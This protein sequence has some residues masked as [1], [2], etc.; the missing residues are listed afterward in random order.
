MNRRRFLR[1]SY[2]ISGV[3]LLAGTLRAERL[4]SSEPEPVEKY[5]RFIGAKKMVVGPEEDLL[6]SLAENRAQSLLKV[7][8]VQNGF[9]YI[10]EGQPNNVIFRYELLSAASECLDTCLLFF[11]RDAAS[12][13]VYRST[14][15]GFHL[16]A[17]ASMIDDPSLAGCTGSL[18][19]ASVIPAVQGKSRGVP[20]VIHMQKGSLQVEVRVEDRNHHISVRLFQ[21]IP[22]ED[23]ISFNLSRSV[24][25]SF[26]A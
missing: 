7:G 26:W 23:E 6:K 5:L 14:L 2:T 4:L 15:T 25:R 1:N 17:L 20:G 19:R 13:W 10:L 21:G 12:G 16:D 22:G 18:D 8:Y 9:P 11:E 3:V 24:G